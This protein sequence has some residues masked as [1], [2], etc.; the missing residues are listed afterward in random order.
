LIDLVELQSIA[1]IAQ[2]IGVA[3]ILIA[4][5]IAVRSYININKKAEESKKKEQETRDRELDTRRAQL[6][7]GAYQAIVTPEMMETY[8][9]L[10]DIHME[11]IQDW[12]RLCKNKERY[13]VWMLWSSYYQELG[14]LLKEKLIDVG[15]L[16]QLLGGNILWFWEQ[17]ES[18][19]IDCR[20]KLNWPSW[21][22]E[23]EYLYDSIIEYGTEHP[24]SGLGRSARITQP[25]KT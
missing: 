14:T 12:N 24:E 4:A 20:E 23:I 16:A 25:R 22:K 7:M 13:K 9:K 1:Y 5:F 18:M 19:M 8:L 2:V 17:Y 21:G 11:D 3:G 6:L 10:Q 15:L